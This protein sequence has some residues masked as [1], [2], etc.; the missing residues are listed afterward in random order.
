MRNLLVFTCLFFSLN[1][2][3]QTPREVIQEQLDAYN[4]KDID[5]FMNVFSED[6]EISTLGDS[7]PSVVGSEN[8]RE[9]YS[10]LFNHSP[11]LHSEVL[12]RTI[13]GNKVIDYEKITGRSASGEIL[14]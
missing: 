1:L 7:I 6:I 5:A 2:F 9:V 12:N 4:A 10:W 8:V 14:F 11:Q 13:L 3:S